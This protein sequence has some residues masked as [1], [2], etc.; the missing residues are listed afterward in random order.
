MAC[1]DY[2]PGRALEY[3]DG[4]CLAPLAAWTV[5]GWRQIVSVPNFFIVGAPKCGTTALA[6]Y[7]QEHQQIFMTTPKE[8]NH[9]N[10]DFEYWA[11]DSKTRDGY[12]RLY[13]EAG[14]HHLAIGEASVWYLYSQVAIREILRFNRDAKLIVMLRN[15]VEM[16]PSL[17]SQLLYV[18]DES[19][20]DFERAFALCG[21][22]SRGEAIPPTARKPAFL[23]YDEVGK[24]GAQLQRLY[25][26]CPKE[27]VKII[28]FDDFEADPGEAYGD[29]L[30][31][32]GVPS[33]GRDSFGAVNQNKRHRSGFVARF[34][35]RPP[36]VLMAGLGIVKSVLGFKTVNL[37][38][39]VRDINTEV[40]KREPLSPAMRKALASCFEQDI[41]LLS[42]IIDRDLSHWIA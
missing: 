5:V 20:P 16:I 9:F 38:R 18:G 23:L 13:Q 17:H 30:E 31:F 27:Q 2:P 1:V 40:V 10:S 15:P 7:L 29:V 36:R 39:Y 25:A 42:E 28:L 34:T 32:L 33:A 41:R 14:D 8:P 11:Y 37:M 12:L 19:E 22:R 26:E 6:E 4:T 3:D 21:A 24:L 35:Q